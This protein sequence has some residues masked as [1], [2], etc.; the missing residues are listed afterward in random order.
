MCQRNI[1]QPLRPVTTRRRTTCLSKF[2]TF[3]QVCV[4]QEAK[5][6]ID[7]AVGEAVRKKHKKDVTVASWFL[8]ETPD[9]HNFAPDTTAEKLSSQDAEAELQPAMDTQTC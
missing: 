2:S 5:S 1:V 3:Y 4:C 9:I 8:P 7:L 6:W